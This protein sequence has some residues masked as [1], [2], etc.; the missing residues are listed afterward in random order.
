MAQTNGKSSNG[1]AR[2]DDRVRVAI[3]G[4]CMLFA[5][6]VLFNEGLNQR[7]LW[8]VL[9]LGSAVIAPGLGRR[10]ER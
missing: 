5:V 10:E 6:W 9:A 3:I 2:L 4:G 8:L 7:A 1:K